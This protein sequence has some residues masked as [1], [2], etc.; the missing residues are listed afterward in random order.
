M[1]T[2]GSFTCL[3]GIAVGSNAFSLLLAGNTGATGAQGNTG[4][5]GAGVTGPQGE[6]GPQGNTGVT[7]AGETG[8]TGNTGPQGET[9][10]QGNTG[11]TGAGETG[12]T[13]VAGE[14]GA[15]GVTGAGE[16]G[17]T[18]PQGETGAVGATGVTGAGET[19][20]TGPQGETGAVGATG[21]T[22]AGET[23]A[24]GPQGET[25]A[26]GPAGAGAIIPF[27]SG[28]P[29]ALTSVA[30]GLVGL[31]GF[32]G[33]GSSAIGTTVLG[34]TIDLSGA[35]GLLL[36][37]AYSMPRTGTITDIAAYFSTVLALNLLG[38]T[39]TVQAQL[40]QSTT[41]DNIFSPIPGTVVTLAPALTGVLAIGTTSN[42]ILTGLSIPVTAQTR[43][44]LVFSI[45]ATG[46][47][48][49]NTVTGYASGGVSIA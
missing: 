38:T 37:M 13:G 22:G 17:A 23:G 35:A 31:P 36:N 4:V 48:L 44:L 47:N 20:A 25:G 27:A 19:G 2:P 42:G 21:V 9:G 28:T 32:V 34:A 43:I 33:F 49:V 40:Y 29:L 24:T 39:V 5:T 16:T 18:G 3:N 8:A 11:V 7:G 26:T 6:T 41:P 10:P 30:L 1:A 14:T 12:A 15:T 46:L 45:T